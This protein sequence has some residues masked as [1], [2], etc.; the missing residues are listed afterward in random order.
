MKPKHFYQILLAVTLIMF[1]SQMARTEIPVWG[2]RGEVWKKLQGFE[3]WLYIQ[4]LLDGLVFSGN[5]IHG[6]EIQPKSNQ[7]PQESLNHIKMA[8][9]QFYDDYRNVQI[10]VPFAL[11]VIS[12]E[13]KG[14]SRKS[15][16]DELTKLRKTFYEL[17]QKNAAKGGARGTTR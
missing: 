12:M 5:K 14:E 4:G 10:P 15:I 3:K 2:T 11:K 7:D 17:D 13:M 9:D 16:E 8:I 6:V 1:S